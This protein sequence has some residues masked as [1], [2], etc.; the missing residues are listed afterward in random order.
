MEVRKPL[1]LDD[2]VKRRALTPFRFLRGVLCLLVLISTALMMLVYLGF[3]SAVIVRLFSIRYSK[4]MSSRIF[5]CWLSLWPFLFE[6]INDTRVVF[7]GETVPAKESILLLANH[8]TEVD[9]MYIWDL[10][11]RKGRLG[12]I[13]KWDVDEPIMHQMLSTMNDPQD[14][15]WLA[16]F[17]E[18]TDF[19]EQKCIQSQ[20]YAADHGLPILTNV[21]LPKAK[22]FFVCMEKLRNSLDAVYD[23][24]VG[25]KP[26][27]PT[28]RD[29][30]FGVNPS[31]VHI[32]IR[33]LPVSS[34]PDSEEEVGNWLTDTFHLKD[35]LLSEFYSRGHF[36][37][38]GT[39]SELSMT[40]CLVNFVVALTLTSIC[41]VLTFSSLRWLTYVLLVCVY[42]E[43]ATKFNFR[44]SPIFCFP[45][46][47]RKDNIKQ[48]LD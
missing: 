31:E 46:L 45:N 32:H 15:I 13:K 27:C 47:W 14:P 7:S 17:P 12:D 26:R 21:L 10:A 35:K 41:I 1:A 2:E 22:G 6:K 19:T 34:I 44:P 9:W 40:K 20:K 16:I 5:A 39:E 24:T 11:L 25:Y 33:R 18:G 37:N 36:P 43:F 28:L 48:A 8:R 30:V 42:L 29:N 3:V 38:E 4:R 23:V